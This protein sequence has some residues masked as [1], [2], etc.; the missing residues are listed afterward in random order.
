MRHAVC[1]QPHDIRIPHKI[2]TEGRSAGIY[3]AHVREQRFDRL[4]ERLVPSEY[5]CLFADRIGEHSLHR[6][7]TLFFWLLTLFPAKD[8]FPKVSK[9]PMLLDRN[10]ALFLLLVLLL[11][12]FFPQ[13]CKLILERFVLSFC[14]RQLVLQILECSA[15]PPDLWCLV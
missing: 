4:P 14:L 12:G 8:E 9:L 11:P 5:N 3:K 7:R 1:L 10:S 13:C 2:R 6:C 15:F